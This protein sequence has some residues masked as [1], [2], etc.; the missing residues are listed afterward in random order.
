MIIFFLVIATKEEL[1]GKVK[2]KSI[3]LVMYS[4]ERLLSLSNQI[5]WF[6]NRSLRIPSD[7]CVQMQSVTF[8][9]HSG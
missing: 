2:R 1:K 7:H 6:S 4:E 8:W 3:P 5:F 9:D